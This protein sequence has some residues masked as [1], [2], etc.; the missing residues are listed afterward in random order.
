M[1]NLESIQ[2][3]GPKMSELLGKLKIY[4]LEDLIHFYPFR[5]NVLKRS[6]LTNLEEGSK[7]IIDGIVEGTPTIIYLNRGLK[8]MIFRISNRRTIL[9]ITIYYFICNC[10]ILSSFVVL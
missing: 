3:I 2:G 10:K 8:K 6:D 4:D 5:Y 1:S 9:N 7:V